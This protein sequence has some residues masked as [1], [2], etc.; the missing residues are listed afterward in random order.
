MPLRPT[1]ISATGFV[2]LGLFLVLGGCASGEFPDEA[3][4]EEELVERAGAT[5][6][7]SA[8]FC[9][10][11]NG[12]QVVILT[13]F[14][15]AVRAGENLHSPVQHDNENIGP[16]NDE[17][18]KVPYRWNVE[19]RTVGGQQVVNFRKPV[20]GNYLSTAN[21]P[22]VMTVAGNADT[23]ANL[24]V[25]RVSCNPSAYRI[26]GKI[27]GEG[28]YR[29]MVASLTTQDPP[30]GPLLVSPAPG[31]TGTRFTFDVAP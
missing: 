19:C 5:V 2:R 6:A 20:S 27:P 21:Y 30:E 12:R 23:F 29:P 17:T 1:T 16:P 28:G 25:R 15:N 11:W 18:W 10:A 3:L 26:S 14:G 24:M 8:T 13:D 22:A 7:D 31:A 9:Q 4:D